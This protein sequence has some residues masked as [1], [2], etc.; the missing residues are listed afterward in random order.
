[1]DVGSAALGGDLSSPLWNWILGALGRFLSSLLCQVPIALV[2][3]GLHESILESSAAWGLMW[4][5]CP[6]ACH[7]LRKG[8]SAPTAWRDVGWA[9]RGIEL[10]KAS[11]TGEVQMDESNNSN[12]LLQYLIYLNR[13]W[14]QLS[15]KSTQNQV[16]VPAVVQHALLSFEL[17]QSGPCTLSVKQI[18]SLISS[19]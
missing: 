6:I 8:T 3:G 4:R 13:L 2:R 9:G 11:Q 18:G 12:N 16:L 5:W 19:L 10:C 17:L 15:L 7:S 14:G 1:M